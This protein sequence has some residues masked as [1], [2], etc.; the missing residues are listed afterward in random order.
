MKHCGLGDLSMTK[1]NKL[2]CFINRWDRI[3]GFEKDLDSF[4]KNFEGKKKQTWGNINKI[5]QNGHQENN[6]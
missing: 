3:L 2:S 6:V 5:K 1:Q 4:N